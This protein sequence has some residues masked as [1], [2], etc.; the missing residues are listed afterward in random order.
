MRTFWWWLVAVSSPLLD[1]ASGKF[2]GRLLP[3]LCDWWKFFVGKHSTLAGLSAESSAKVILI[4]SIPNAI[5]YYGPP[6]DFFYAANALAS[7]SQAS[8]EPM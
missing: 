8:R 1:T 3:G 6:L 4:N 2:N 7:S 5:R